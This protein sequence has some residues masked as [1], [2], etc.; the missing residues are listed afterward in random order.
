M[1]LAAALLLAWPWLS[2]AVTVPWDAKSQFFPQQAFMARAFAGGEWPFWT[3]NV[4]AGWPQIADPQS[5]IFS[6]PHVLLALFQP[7]AGFRATDAVSFAALLA[8]ALGIVGLFRDRGWHGAGALVAALA[9]MFGGACASRLQHTGQILSVAYF[10]LALWLLSR[11]LERS[12]VRYGLGAGLAAALIALGRDQVALLALYLL[13]AWVLA[14]WLDGAGRARRLRGSVKPLVAAGGLALK[15]AIVAIGMTWLLASESNRPAIDYLEAARGSL[16]PMHFLTLVFADLYGAADPAVPYWGPASF[17]WGETGLVLAQNMGQLYAGAL[18]LLAVAAV[19]L[20]GN[21]LWAKDIRVITIM[22]LAAL[23]YAV[24][25]YAPLFRI[26]YEV[27]PGITLYRRP[28]DAAFLFGAL[29]AILGGYAVHRLLLLDGS[30]LRRALTAASIAGLAAVSAALAGA[31]MIGMLRDAAM[32]ILIGAAWL[33]AGL[34]TLWFVKRYAAAPLLV[35][36]IL[37]AFMAADLSFNNAPNESTGLPPATYEALLADTKND[38]VG[39]LRARLAATA[40][41]DRRD[42]VELTAIA[43][44]WPNLSQAQNFDGLFGQNP[45]R[46]RDFAQATGVGDTVAVA[47]QRKFAPLLPSYRS[48][49]ADMLGLRFIALGVPI[50]QI[51]PKLQPGDIPLIAR[52]R[53]AYIYENPRALPRVMV[54]PSAR[55]AD[56]GALLRDGWPA[57]ADPRQTVLLEKVP[58]LDA[59]SRRGGDAVI[60]RYTNTEI[61]VEADAVDGGYLVLNDVWHPWWRATLDGKPVEILKANALFRGVALPPGKHVVTFSFHPIAGAIAQLRRRFGFI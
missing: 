22:T 47:D 3:A 51:D 11:A 6:P 55:Q 18:P 10:P 37:A 21:A 28:A 52:T 17:P 59:A 32:P 54:A 16:H 12:S 26:L 50:E 61:M 1:L 46:L 56:F 2:G 23:M 8:G 20:T 40:A 15:L 45:L 25:W 36:A 13:A 34:A 44:H 24:G 48:A 9:F 14:H 58:P 38:T 5:L 35:A 57:D 19:G 27:L 4:F 31:V 49:M 39:L 29:F 42:R 33:A 41:P 53:D 7:Q 30:A 60:R 43:Y